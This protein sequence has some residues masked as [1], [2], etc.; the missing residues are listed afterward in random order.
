MANMW[1]D[2]A[3]ILGA[4]LLGSLPHLSALAKLRGIHLEGDL[5]ISL[6]RGGG[7][8]IGVIGILIELI[9]GIIPILVGKGLGFDLFIIALAG[10]A[11]VSG[12]MWPIFTRFD[13]EKGNSIGL[14]M[15]GALAPIAL[16][17][18]LVPIAIGA[19]IR[20]V[21]CLLDTS[22]SLNERLKFSEPSNR[23][24]PRSM[25]LAMALGFLVLPIANWWWGEPLAITSALFAL[26]I[27][28]MVR[29]LT[30]GL[31]DD[32]K[33]NADVKGILIN[34]LLYDRSYR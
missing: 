4:Y 16:F 10:L 14:A 18:A 1:A 7:R 25:P 6:W 20:A 15:A 9:K 33:L 23:S 17:I 28:I 13:G 32:L 29:R 3:L 31:R 19:V 2:I 8:L 24:R 22:Q 30:A 11:A 21:P 34:R 26:F 12:Q 5:H 27:L